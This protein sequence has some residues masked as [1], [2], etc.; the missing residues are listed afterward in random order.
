MYR[1]YTERLPFAH[2]NRVILG[3]VADALGYDAP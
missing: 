2:R 1:Q 3:R